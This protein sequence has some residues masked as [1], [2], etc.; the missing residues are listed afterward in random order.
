MARLAFIGNQYLK[1]LVSKGIISNSDCEY[2]LLNID[3]V[4]SDL[5][6]DFNR[7]L[8]RKLNIG[9]FNKLYGHLR[10]G[11]YDIK[12]LP[13]NKDS[14]Y[15]S[16]RSKANAKGKEQKRKQNNLKEFR[17]GITDFLVNFEI[18]LSTD[19]LLSFIEE[20]TKLRESF[21]FEFTK[22]LSFALELLVDVG[23]QLG[24][25][26]AKLSN[27][28]IESLMCVTSSTAIPDIIDLWS[29]QISGKSQ[30]DMIYDYITLHH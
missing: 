27:L 26:R 28:S 2:F 15:F 1:G 18:S 14:S 11:T 20:T 17:E 23:K 5:S 16:L 12:K 7:V 19:H 3:T 13:Y 21:K 4:A 22:N 10:P 29:S 24:F 30:N 8:S 9:D 6:N 25:E